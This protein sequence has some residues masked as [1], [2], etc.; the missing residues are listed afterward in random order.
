MPTISKSK[1]GSTSPI[2]KQVS[3]QPQQKQRRMGQ[4]DEAAFFLGVS[5]Q[6]MY[7][8]TRT[9]LPPGV[10][11]RLGKQLRFDLDALSEWA[12]NGGTGR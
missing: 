2:A 10:F 1:R 8:L 4:V 6:R 11:V 7:E 12:S 5:R 9:V 3:L